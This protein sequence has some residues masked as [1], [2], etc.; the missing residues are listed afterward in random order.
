M[1]RLSGIVLASVRVKHWL[2]I[3]DT[4]D[5]AVIGAQNGSRGWEEYIRKDFASAASSRKWGPATPTYMVD[6]VYEADEER[7]RRLQSLPQG[8]PAATMDPCGC[9]ESLFI[10]ILRDPVERARSH[11]RM[12]SVNGIEPMRTTF[13]VVLSRKGIN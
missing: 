12:E 10:A 5:F 9:H 11:H 6:R 8:A 1:A 2:A 3:K 7:N 13:P 4:L